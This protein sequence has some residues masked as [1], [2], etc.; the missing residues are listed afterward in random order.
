MP[1]V[2][3]HPLEKGIHYIKIYV[4]DEFLLS[5]GKLNKALHRRM[6]FGEKII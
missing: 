6:K 2:E 3:G 4:V 5:G 1:V